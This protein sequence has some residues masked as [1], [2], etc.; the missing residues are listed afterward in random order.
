[1][2]AAILGAGVA[3]LAL[4]RRLAERGIDV[5]LF[6]K[7]R[8]PSGRLSTRRTDAGQFDH[9]AQYLT[10]RDP[11]FRAAVEGWVARGIVAPWPGRI[12]SLAGGSSRPDRASTASPS[13]PPAS[14]AQASERFVGRPRMSALARELLGDRPIELGVRIERAVRDAGRWTLRSETGACYPD[15][16][17]LLLAVPAPQA[18]PFLDCVPETRSRVAG[19]EMLP[20][21]ALMVRFADALEVGFEGAFVDEPELSWVAHDGAKP[22][23]EG[24]PCWVLHSRA[25]WSKTNVDLEPDGVIRAL[26]AGFERALGRALPEVVFSSSHRW[27]YARTGAALSDGAIWH[28]EHGLGLCGDWLRGDRVE[29]AYLSGEQLAQQV[30]A[31]IGT[32]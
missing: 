24:H 29:D 23:R 3:G 19:V 18:L 14:T 26:L 15:F 1:M 25:A 30:S 32:A 10:A 17:L 20:C 7:A 16:E 13:T 12:V 8:G 9:G 5:R 22:G 31:S 2:R 21:H 6:E 11:A 28:P 27:L 4:A